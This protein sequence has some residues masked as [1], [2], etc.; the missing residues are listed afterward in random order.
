MALIKVRKIARPEQVGLLD[1]KDPSLGVVWERWVEPEPAAAPADGLGDAAAPSAPP[2]ADA[3]PA[4]EPEGKRGGK[5]G[6]KKGQ[7]ISAY[8]PSFVK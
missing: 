2:P 1:E 4:P 3:P 8:D 5:K 7:D 6:G